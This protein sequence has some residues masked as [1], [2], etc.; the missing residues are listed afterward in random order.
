M[1]PYSNITERFQRKI[2]KDRE[3]FDINN[4][5]VEELIEI[6]NQYSNELLD[7]AVNEI[8]PL[9]SIN[10]KVNFLNKDD[11]IEQ[12]NFELTTLEEDFISDMM[13]VKL[14]DEEM[15]KLK[16]MQKYLGD[17]IKVFSPAQERDSFIKM[18]DYKRKLTLNKIANYNTRDRLTG[19]FLLP[20]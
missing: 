12:F 5:S 4:V 2:K 14:L 11:I 3:F 6:V 7:D 9:I 17:D 18:I 16:T 13:Y 1:T 15:V 8:Q 19:E 10:Q 20:Y